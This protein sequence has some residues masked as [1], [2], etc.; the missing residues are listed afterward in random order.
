MNKILK[1][2]NLTKKLQERGY[3]LDTALLNELEDKRA[4]SVIRANSFHLRATVSSK[5]L[6]INAFT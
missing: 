6:H 4:K 5:Y 1:I 2:Q 3:T